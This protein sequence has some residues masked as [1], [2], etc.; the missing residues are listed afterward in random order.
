MLAYPEPES[1]LNVDV[2]VLLRQGDLIG[3][4]GLVRWGCEEWRCDER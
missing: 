2:A 1:P 3:A 4:E